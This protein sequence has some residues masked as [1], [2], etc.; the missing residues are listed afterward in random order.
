MRVSSSSTCTPQFRADTLLVL[1]GAEDPQIGYAGPQA[2]R[3]RVAAFETAFGHFAADCATQ[4]DCPL[5]NDPAAAEARLVAFLIALGSHPLPTKDGRRLT[6]GDATTGIG[7]A[8]Y[9]K[10]LWPRLRQGLTAA[11]AADGSILIRLADALWQRDKNGRYSN[12]IDAESAI[13]CADNPETR[14]V[15]QIKADNAV[16]A[17]D[18]P[19]FGLGA[20]GSLCQF[21]PV[22]ST[23]TPHAIRAPGAA[24][25]LVVGTTGDPVT[26]YVWARSLAG[27]LASAR[28]LTYDGEGHT[29]YGKGHPCVDQ[30]VEDYLVNGTLPATD[31]QCPA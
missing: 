30:V 14:T 17:R 5:P 7:A 24:P 19:L 9:D 10:R 2:E 12:L 16:L 18:H 28:L 23:I 1:D 29:A 21:W 25:I 13:T 20:S 15:E 11:F 26:P 4:R 22:R 27:Q 8:L 3:T 6:V 31:T